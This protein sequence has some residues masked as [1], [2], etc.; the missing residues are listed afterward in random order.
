MGEAAFVVMGE[1]LITAVVPSCVRY[2]ATLIVVKFHV[3]F[4]GVVH[5]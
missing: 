2:L 5:Y 3:Y 1:G 4:D